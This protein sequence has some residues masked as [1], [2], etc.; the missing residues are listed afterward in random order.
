[1]AQKDRL[2][3]VSVNIGKALGKAEKQARMRARQL[4]NASV[5]AK[6][7]LE[8]ISKQVEVL[9]KQLAKATDRLKKALSE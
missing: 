1:M 2:T 4:N 9:K 6:E 5:V 8:E 3:E 7:E